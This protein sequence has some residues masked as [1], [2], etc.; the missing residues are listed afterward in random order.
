MALG[1][2]LPT[3]RHLDTGNRANFNNGDGAIALYADLRKEM[4]DPVTPPRQPDFLTPLPRPH[5][6]IQ[7]AVVNLVGRLAPLVPVTRQPSL[8]R[9]IAEVIAGRPSSM[10]N[11]MFVRQSIIRGGAA[12]DDQVIE[13]LAAWVTVLFDLGNLQ[14]DRRRALDVEA[15]IPGKALACLAHALSKSRNGCILAVPHI[16][17]IELFAAHLKDHGFNLGFVYS[18]SDQPTLTERWIYEGRRA[19]HGT[20][21]AFGRRNTGAEISQVLANNG[22]VVMVVDVYPSAR[23]KGIVARVHDAEFNLPPGPGRY[24]RSG[25]L[26]LP[27]FASRRDERGFAMNI[28]API[29]YHASMP[30][31]DAAAALTQT[32]ASHI[33]GFTAEQPEAY[34]LWHPIPNDPYLA[35]A[36]RYRPDLL[37]A[38][39]A[40]PPDDE[41]TALAVEAASA[42][43]T[44]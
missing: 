36:Q 6:D 26:I 35:V 9:K 2:D 4:T 11:N 27:G 25:T 38:S 30:E 44:T 29:E 17:S 32:L 19:V 12:T 41:A 13:G 40:P 18:I 23:F 7:T 24:A 8:A 42:T 39:A 14:H 28:L 20:P 21:I 31:Q 5:G 34:W 22:V 15:R 16:G 1:D 10:A 3:K 37:N 43:L 33:A